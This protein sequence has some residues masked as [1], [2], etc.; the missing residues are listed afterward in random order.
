M[1]LS[2]GYVIIVYLT[3]VAC[4]S[5]DSQCRLIPPPINLKQS[6][7][8]ANS[9]IDKPTCSS[10]CSS[11]ISE[12]AIWIVVWL[13]VSMSNASHNQQF[14]NNSEYPFSKNYLHAIEH[15]PIYLP[16]QPDSKHSI[17]THSDLSVPKDERFWQSVHFV[18]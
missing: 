11:A 5:T 15:I 17:K 1:I 3:I 13:L 7:A 16:Q 8:V 12:S 9:T 2:C 10:F 6:I 14:E 4:T 18:D